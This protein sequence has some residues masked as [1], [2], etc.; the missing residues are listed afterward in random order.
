VPVVA[1]VPD[2]LP[3]AVQLV[4]R[5]VDHVSFVVAPDVTDVGA[6]DSVTVGLMLMN[7]VAVFDPPGPLQVS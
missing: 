2:Q 7:A 3:E 5:V 6:A 1:F 4:A